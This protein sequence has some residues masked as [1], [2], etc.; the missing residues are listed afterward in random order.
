M[1]FRVK[2]LTGHH[3]YIA[4]IFLLSWVGFPSA[5]AENQV[6]MITQLNV[7]PDRC[8]AL[9][10]GQVCYQSVVFQWSSDRQG[11]YCLVNAKTDKV[12]KCWQGTQQAKLNYEIESATTQQ[13]YLSLKNTQTPL[14]Q[15]QV[16]V[17]WVYD[18]NAHRS[19]GWRLF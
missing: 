7:K 13:F 10:Q 5:Y 14:R 1:F 19:S 3:T 2:N 6:G 17:A 11:D 9:R 18:Q 12:I 15:V 8:V 16:K 4:Y